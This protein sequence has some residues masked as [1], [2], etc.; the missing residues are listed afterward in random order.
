MQTAPG[1]Y[2]LTRFVADNPGYWIMHCHISFDQIEGQVLVVKV[3]NREDW[4]IPED[5]PK[6]GGGE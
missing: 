6:C 3:G 5:F 2:I 1:R 4:K